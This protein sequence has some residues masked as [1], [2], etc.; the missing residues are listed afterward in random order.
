MTTSGFLYKTDPSDHLLA[1]PSYEDVRSRRLRMVECL[2]A[3]HDSNMMFFRACGDANPKCI[4]YAAINKNNLKIY[5]G[6]TERGISTRSYFHFYKAEHNGKGLFS[7]AIR[8]H[9]K[10]SFEFFILVKC[11]DFFDALVKE[12]QYISAIMPEYNMTAGGGGIKGYKFTPEQIEKGVSKRRGKPN[13]KKGTSLSSEERAR[14]STGVKKW[15]LENSDRL[16]LR[17]IAAENVKKA[18]AA[19]EKPVE[20]IE[21]NRCFSS[22]SKAARYYEIDSSQVIYSCRMFPNHKP[23]KHKSFKYIEKN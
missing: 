7:S 16:G 10:D 2:R 12:R 23:R 18:I 13:K 11:K 4:V 17:L 15:H 6:A 9:G 8:K 22:A 5:V 14:V 20:C 21:D 3:I 1:I 19:R